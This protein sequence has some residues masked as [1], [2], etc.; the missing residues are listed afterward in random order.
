MFEENTVKK[1]TLI[2]L[3]TTLLSPMVAANNLSPHDV[4]ITNEERIL[5]WLKKRDQISSSELDSSFKS[6]MSNKDVA[7]QSIKNGFRQFKSSSNVFSNTNKQQVAFST[8]LVPDQSVNDVKVLAILIDFPD[9]KHD[10]NQL[11]EQDTDMFYAD[12]STEHYQQMLFNTQGYTGPDGQSLKTAAD[13]YKAASGNS[14]NF[15]GQVYG[16]V[17]ANSN[18]KIYGERQGSTR[19]INAP[20]LIKELSLIHI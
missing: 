14:L 20:A 12:Y 3:L 6:Y 16:W 4:G 5:Y 9:L 17:T 10:D 7:N 18:A 11:V 1:V 15:S 13:Y 2:A 19:D 8:S